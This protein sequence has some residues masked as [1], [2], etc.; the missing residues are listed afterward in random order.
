MLFK[1]IC[2]LSS[3]LHTERIQSDG[4]SVYRKKDRLIES[5]FRNCDILP[6]FKELTIVRENSLYAVLRIFI[7]NT[8]N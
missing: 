4:K 6:S 2:F 1:K 8:A 5:P 7:L 3:I